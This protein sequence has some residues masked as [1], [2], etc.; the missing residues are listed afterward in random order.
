MKI[1][2][3]G[4]KLLADNPAGPEIYTYNIVSALARVDKEN[5]YS[6]FFDR[7][8]PEGYFEK[9][10]GGNSRFSY[11][12][13]SSFP[14]WTQ[15]HL[16]VQLLKTPVDV[17]F[18]PV[19]T[20]P[21]IRSKKLKVVGMIHGLEYLSNTKRKGSKVFSAA[22]I[23][24]LAEHA[25][26]LI[27][28][29]EYTKNSL[30]ETPWG[31]RGDKIGVIPEGVGHEFFKRDPLEGVLKGYGIEAGKYLLAISTIQPRKNY[32]R[33]IEAFSR[34]SPDYPDFKLVIC[35]KKGWEYDETFEA[36]Q[37]YGISDKVLFP[38][39]VPD[40]DLPFLLSGAV[41]FV[42]A[43]LEEGFGL[44]LLEAMACETSCVVSDLP[45]YK[46]IG[47]ESMIYF[48][49]MNVED[50]ANGLSKALNDLWVGEGIV[51]INMAKRRA[52]EFTWEK[53]AERTLA[54]FKQLS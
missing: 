46:D 51:R 6:V 14:S 28:P 23:R 41:L 11:K 10:T 40:E 49:P 1:G 22:P 27:V 20:M 3:S 2:I 21:I 35:G 15:F 26:H 32:P 30:L 42:S 44:P 17:F 38:G 24:F 48:D 19:H 36:P 31:V 52:L 53:A 7:K 34:I 4:Q 54:V 5:D 25:D 33:L 12:V 29:S 37:K 39:R 16:A 8:V 9:L 13:L 45:S 47:Q 43:S 50:I 18:T